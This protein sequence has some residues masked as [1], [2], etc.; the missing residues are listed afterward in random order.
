MVLSMDALR[1]AAWIRLDRLCLADLPSYGA[2]GGSYVIREIESGEV[3]YIGSTG[4]LRRRL[5]GNHLGGVGGDTTQR[6]HEEE[7]A[8]DAVA[9][10]EMTWVVT[11]EWKALEKELK[12]Q[13]APLA[14][15][16]LPRW[17]RR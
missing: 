4:R 16:S 3:V 11:D 2:V 10:L 17:V 1:D 15:N 5:F 12:R 9:R 6:I 14:P 13:F 8:G 7:F